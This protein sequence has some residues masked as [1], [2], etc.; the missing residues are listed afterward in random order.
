MKMKNFVVVLFLLMLSTTVVTSSL[1]SRAYYAE[2]KLT[3]SGMPLQFS[4]TSDDSTNSG[5]LKAM[6]KGSIYETGEQMTV[7]GACMDGWG[8]LIANDNTLNA[9]LTSWYPNGTIW[10]RDQQMVVVVDPDTG[11][12]SG[13]YEYQVNMGTVPGT[14]LTEITCR[15]QGD[16]ANAYGEWQNP[17]WVARIKQIQDSNAL[18][19]GNLTTQ[20][21]AFS[22]TVQ[23][24][25]STVINGISN[26]SAQLANQTVDLTALDPKFADLY[27]GIKGIDPV[28]WTVDDTWPIIYGGNA[29]FAGWKVD[30]L[31]AN[32]IYVIGNQ[33]YTWNGGTDN[34]YY[35]DGYTWSAL[36]L[37]T[38]S[39]TPQGVSVLP[40]ASPYAWV[41][42][43]E[44]ISINGG[45]YIFTGLGGDTQN[46]VTGKVFQ[47]N[48][49]EAI[50]AYAQQ[51]NGDLAF[52]NDSGT[53]WTLT[54]GSW[55]SVGLGPYAG[56]SNILWYD[57]G[58]QNNYRALFTSD[59]IDDVALYYDGTNYVQTDAPP[60]GFK[61]SKS[62]MLTSTLGYV[63]ADDGAGQSIVLEFNGTSFKEV[64]RSDS[65]LLTGITALNENDIWVT[66][67][68]P[69]GFYHYNGINW[70]HSSYPYS[71][72]ILIGFGSNLSLANMKDLK[73]IDSKVGYAISDNGV[74]LKLTSHYDVRLDAVMSK[75]NNQTELFAYLSSMNITLND[76]KA[77]G[78][79]INS[80]TYTTLSS[81]LAMN[82]TLVE[83]QGTTYAIN[84][85]MA[86]ALIYLAAINDTTI[87]T[88]LNTAQINTTVNN[89]DANVL[90]S[91]VYLSSM[92][93]SLNGLTV[94]MAQ[95]LLYLSG[96]NI[97]LTNVETK[98]DQANAY[99]AAQN[100]TL[101]N[102]S[103][104][105]GQI[106]TMLTDLGVTVN[107]INATQ[108]QIIND[109]SNMNMTLTTVN[110]N[111]QTTMDNLA[112]MNLTLVDTYAMTSSINTSLYDLT[113]IVLS[114]NTS[115]SQDLSDIKLQI[116]DMNASLSLALI[117]IIAN[118]T[119]MQLYLETTMY[120]M[121][122]A[123]YQNTLSILSSLGI[124]ETQLNQTIQI[125]N[126][127]LNVT[128]DTQAG[129]NELVNKSRRIR[130]W[131]TV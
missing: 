84:Q 59:A 113:Q 12:Q 121:M 90:S 97:T 6:L 35:W 27:G 128:L 68:S 71:A 3:Q 100:I 131:I 103:L 101:N 53:T 112:A 116:A 120:P 50:M 25:F 4:Q 26:L 111:V 123:T 28:Y 70:Q 104:S 32:D 5:K 18:Y 48:P 94:D 7:F 20:I 126:Q 77:L 19:Y 91:L 36:A 34:V 61:M 114:M 33:P 66:G 117:E 24:N 58:N 62:V 129:V 109:L 46:Y 42:T 2:I 22:N 63:L 8:Y 23:S 47:R 81:L 38:T 119:Y 124:I 1:M 118:Q 125:A 130:A 83:V 51:S 93:I 108:L 52:S 64:F 14:Y 107:N 73:M 30:V 127:T 39:A 78:V 69:V 40:A 55:P 45:A 57:N 16:I 31:S 122:N 76:V 87:Q 13:R 75:L 88:L 49:G 92:N 85:S 98:V 86:Q 72:G 54:T 21:D 37:P 74:L 82:Y 65:A 99:L 96:M 95:A 105:T 110:N 106:I 29:S 44:G 15:Y 10:E 56:I 11:N 89:I 102:I 67:D 41:F 17:N 43:D 80:T 79:E 9:T 60:S 115:M